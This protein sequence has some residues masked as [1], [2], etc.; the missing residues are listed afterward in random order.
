MADFI[1]CSLLHGK[2]ETMG[3]G[4]DKTSHNNYETIEWR[5]E[6]IMPQEDNGVIGREVPLKCKLNSKDFKGAR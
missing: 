1:E 6:T 4:G 3:S 5:Y 2:S